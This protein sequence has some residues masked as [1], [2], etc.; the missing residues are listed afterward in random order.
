MAFSEMHEL[1]SFVWMEAGNYPV[2]QLHSY[3]ISI[4]MKTAGY[5]S[6]PAALI[7]IAIYFSSASQYLCRMAAACA[8]VALPCGSKILPSLPLTMLFMVHQ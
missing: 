8:R 5:I 6:Y 7:W 2:G 1:K 4:G 3:R